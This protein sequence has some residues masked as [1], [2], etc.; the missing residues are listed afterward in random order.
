MIV[1]KIRSKNDPEKFLT[2]TP[3]YSRWDKDGRLF[4]TLGKLR[5]FITNS[6]KCK[7]D[8]GSWDII[9][10]EMVESAVKGVYDVIDPK[11]VWDMLKK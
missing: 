8:I 9:E 5:T 7:K 2:G 3:N 10:F 1:Y 11:K 4:L 6:M